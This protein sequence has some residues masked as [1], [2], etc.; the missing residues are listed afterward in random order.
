MGTQIHH[1]LLLRRLLLPRPL[2][3]PTVVVA[4]MV[5]LQSFRVVVMIITTQGRAVG[6]RKSK[7]ALAAVGAMEIL[8]RSI[9]F[10]VEAM[11]AVVTC[12][13][14]MVLLEAMG[15]GLTWGSSILRW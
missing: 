13:A 1:R 7:T 14:D 8:N 2:G 3:I 12:M 5:N 15:G 9:D 11:E 4:L 10:L 6:Q